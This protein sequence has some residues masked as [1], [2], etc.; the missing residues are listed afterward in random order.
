MKMS[1][2]FPQKMNLSYHVYIFQNHCICLIII[3]II[4][5]R[6]KDYKDLHTGDDDPKTDIRAFIV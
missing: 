6:C 5:V 1:L 2:P 3:V 4:M